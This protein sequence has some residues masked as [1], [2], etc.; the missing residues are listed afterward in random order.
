MDW[1]DEAVT[2]TEGVGI[3]RPEGNRDLKNTVPIQSVLWPA[4]KSCLSIAAGEQTWFSTWKHSIN[5]LYFVV[6]YLIHEGPVAR[7]L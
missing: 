6:Q 3:V 5:V 1:E 7:S 2:F 4:K